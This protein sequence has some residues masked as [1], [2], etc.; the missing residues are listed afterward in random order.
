MPNRSE[1]SELLRQNPVLAVLRAKHAREYAPVMETLAEG[2]IRCI[3]LTLSTGGVLDQLPSLA[4]A[5]GSDVEIGI[6]T[7]T[8]VDEA[9]RAVDA[10]ARFLVTPLMNEAIV[11][12]GVAAG[13][14]VFPGGANSH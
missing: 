9:S 5:F 13:I 2:D 3:E 6:G 11:Y 4:A 8:T 14:P 12:V 7:V 1:P 10:G